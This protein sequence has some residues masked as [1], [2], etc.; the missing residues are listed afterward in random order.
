MFKPEDVIYSYTRHQAI[1]DGVLVDVSETAREAG[2]KYPTALT[3]RVWAELVDPNEQQKAWGQDQS[4]RLWD[5][6]FM[7]AHSARRNEGVT[8]HYQLLVVRDRVEA[9][10]ITLKAVCGPGDDPEPVITIMFPDED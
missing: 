10:E 4:G 3:A 7:F 2:V 6:L 5:V 9:D 1:E 8:L